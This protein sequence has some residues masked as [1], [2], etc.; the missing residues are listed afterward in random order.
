MSDENQKPRSEIA[1][2]FNECLETECCKISELES[3]LRILE[4]FTR[5][6]LHEK[7]VGPLEVLNGAYLAERIVRGLDDTRRAIQDEYLQFIQQCGL[8][9][10]FRGYQ[11]ALID[12]L[13]FFSFLHQQYQ[14]EDLEEV[15]DALC[16]AIRLLGSLKLSFDTIYE[17]DTRLVSAA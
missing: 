6:K 16:I 17:A 2:D 13:N 8:A 12:M 1:D 9:E 11:S 3:L 4:A 10:N 15:D 14:G 7:Q 5:A